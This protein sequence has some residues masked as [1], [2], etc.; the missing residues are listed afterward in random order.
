MIEVLKLEIEV[1]E[2]SLSVST[3]FVDKKENE[4]LYEKFSSSALHSNHKSFVKSSETRSCI[5][6][7]SKH[8]SNIKQTETSGLKKLIKQKGLCFVFKEGI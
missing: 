2:C 6:C 4:F 5:F 1:K 3:S 7:G 8:S